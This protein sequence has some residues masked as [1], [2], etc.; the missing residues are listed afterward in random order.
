MRVLIFIAF[1]RYIK[2]P[3][4]VILHTLIV[5]CALLCLVST[6]LYMELFCIAYQP[7]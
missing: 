4:Y 1:Q 7:R 6:A 5:Q 2:T 3:L